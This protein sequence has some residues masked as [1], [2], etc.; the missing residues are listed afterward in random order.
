MVYNK[1]PFAIVGR[2]SRGVT[3]PK[4]LEGRN[5]A[6]RHRTAPT[7][8]GRSLRQANS[9]DTSKVTIENIGFPVREPMLA[10]GQVD[11]ATGYSFSIF[12]NLRDRNVPTDD[13]SISS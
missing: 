2:K 8:N 5:S 1:P 3:N 12:F 11:A 13:I 10:A 6:H 7:H 4:D 9:I